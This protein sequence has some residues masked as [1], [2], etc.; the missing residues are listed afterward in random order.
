MSKTND[1]CFFSLHLLASY[2]LLCPTMLKSFIK[3]YLHYIPMKG[4]T[5][6]AVEGLQRGGLLEGTQLPHIFEI[7]FVM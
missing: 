1:L 4:K 3:Y 5:N 2:Q 7:S 6:Q